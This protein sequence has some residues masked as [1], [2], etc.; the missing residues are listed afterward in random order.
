MLAIHNSTDENKEFYTE[1]RCHILELQN[2]SDDRS[3]SIARARIEVGVTTAWH[4]LNETVESFYILSGMGVIEIGEEVQYKIKPGDT[5]RVPPN[6]AQ[7]ITNTGD[8]DLIFLCFCTPAFNAESY[9][10]LE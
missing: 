6:T 10:S 7:R 1:E 8:S 3:Q 2:I 4:R 5:V 9:V